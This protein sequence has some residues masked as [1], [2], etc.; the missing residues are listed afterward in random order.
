M[1]LIAK[2]N[3]ILLDNQKMLN[4]DEEY[5]YKFKM[6]NT[7]NYIE[8]SFF[9]YKSQVNKI[10][11]LNFILLFFSLFFLLL[12]FFLMFRL[13]NKHCVDKLAD[14]NGFFDDVIAILPN[15]NILPTQFKNKNIIYLKKFFDFKINFKDLI[16][17]YKLIFK[18]FFYPYFWMKCI[19]VIISYSGIAKRSESE[20]LVSNEYSFT[21]SVLTLYLNSYEKTVSNCMH[22][23]KVLCQ[24]DCFSTY[25]N[26]YVWDSYYSNLLKK[27]DVKA[28]FIISTCDALDLNIETNI[29]NNNIVFYLQGIEKTSDLKVIKD[30]LVILSKMYNGSFFVKPHPRY[31]SN[32][33]T[34]V[35]KESEI[36]NLDF[37]EA[38]KM[39]SIICSNYSTVL[40]QVYAYRKNN[41]VP[42]PL[43]VV[44]DLVPLPLMYIMKDK[45]DHL[46]SEI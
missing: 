11:L 36:L 15:K 19:F 16:F 37:N 26:F 43:I 5:F 3:S 28:N 2:V 1:S 10:Y 25:D 32:E 34:M 18:Y 27:M 20:V 41:N 46:F 40:F 14:D 9:Q 13:G 12:P 44:N 33:L 42:A 17:I 35:F 23:E 21:S 4:Y 38:I 29:P 7:K 24:R 8:R 45:A 22:G 39:T 6:K 30:K 31:L